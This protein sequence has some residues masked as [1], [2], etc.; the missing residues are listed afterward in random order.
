MYTVKVQLTSMLGKCWLLDTWRKVWIAEHYK[1]CLEERGKG[2]GCIDV[3]MKKEN[4]FLVYF[5]A[6]KAYQITLIIIK[7]VFDSYFC[8][9]K[10]KVQNILCWYVISKFIY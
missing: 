6:W 8:S 9:N 10:I 1:I 2:W 4:Y 3:T 7:F 5:H